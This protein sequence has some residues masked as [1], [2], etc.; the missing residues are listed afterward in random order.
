[1]DREYKKNDLFLIHLYILTELK[2]Q[3][4]IML[5]KYI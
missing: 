3:L 1:M 2:E 4:E 5:P